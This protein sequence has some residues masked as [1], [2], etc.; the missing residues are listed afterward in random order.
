MSFFHNPSYT[1]EAF[2]DFWGTGKLN[3]G[4]QYFNGSKLRCWSASNGGT[5][6]CNE[7]V[8]NSFKLTGTHEIYGTSQNGGFSKVTWN[9]T[10]AANRPPTNVYLAE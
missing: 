5:I 3:T 7:L 1:G 4:I 8:A 9:S 2:Y 10:R 6:N